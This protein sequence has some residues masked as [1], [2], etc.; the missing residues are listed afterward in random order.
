MSDHNPLNLTVEELDRRQKLITSIKSQLGYNFYD[1]PPE[2]ILINWQTG[3]I[4]SM[5]PHKDQI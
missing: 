4:L 2:P 3:E 1:I 5:P